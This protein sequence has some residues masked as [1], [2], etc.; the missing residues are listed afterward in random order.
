LNMAIVFGAYFSNVG[1]LAALAFPLLTIAILF[2]LF[3]RTT[4]ARARS[5]NL[6]LMLTSSIFLWAFIAFSLILCFAFAETYEYQVAA[7]IRAVLGGALLFGIVVALPF[8]LLLRNISPKVTL[9]K[10]RR[11]S[12]PGKE[13]SDSFDALRKRMGVPYAELRLS[14][15]RAP[16]S[17][18]IHTDKPIVVMSES[19]FALLKKDEVEAVMAHEL[20]H[21]RNS[22]TTLKALVTAYKTALPHDPIIR[23]VEAAFHREREMV[24]DETAAGITKKPLSLASALLKIY[25]AFPKSSLPSLGTLSILGAGSTLMSR[26]PPIRH[27]VSYLINLADIHRQ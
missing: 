13:I 20:A 22:D 3:K 8:S 23:L 27:R 14:E 7:G 17:F 9:A 24:A 25:E 18:A 5:W 12:T 11:L 21:I 10:V 15:S 4:S 16:V 19:L 2:V 1:T 26:H 6:G